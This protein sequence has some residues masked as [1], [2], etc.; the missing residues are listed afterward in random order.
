MDT[1]QQKYERVYWK[2]IV[3]G[4]PVAKGR[5]RSVVRCGHIAHYTPRKTVQYENLVRFSA[6]QVIGQSS[7]LV[8]P[9]ALKVSAYMTIPKSWAKS[10]KEESNAGKVLPT[11]RPDLDNIVKSV[12][13]GLNGIAWLD[14]AQVT[15]IVAS[16][17]YDLNPR[18]EIQILTENEIED[19]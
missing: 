19:F 10:K 13:D 11:S 2:I 17:R 12:K 18:L 5:A 3:P 4:P 1:Q 9:I 7:I 8:G 14:D 6:Q 15:T 16:K